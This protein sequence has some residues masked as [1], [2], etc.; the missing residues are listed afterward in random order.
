[1]LPTIASKYPLDVYNTLQALDMLWLLDD[2]QYTDDELFE[3]MLSDA[4][5]DADD[6][7]YDLPY[8]L[9]PLY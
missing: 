4:G 5:A 6:N 2:I 8:P 7:K 9:Y 1:M 3:A